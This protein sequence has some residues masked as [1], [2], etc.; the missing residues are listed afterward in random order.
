MISI[1]LGQGASQAM[2]DAAAL[3]V[4]LPL[5]TTRTDIPVRLKA[6]EALR[7]ERAEL[8]GRESHDQMMVPSERGKY[9]R[10]A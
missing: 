3:G 8:I 10:G 5:G 6:Y 1:A 4:F 9:M 2:E 7:K